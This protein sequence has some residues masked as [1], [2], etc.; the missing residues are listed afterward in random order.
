MKKPKK[1]K[2]KSP[3]AGGVKKVKKAPKTKKTNKIK[4][5]KETRKPKE[6]EVAKV[7]EVEATAVPFE[8]DASQRKRAGKE[9]K[10]SY[11][12]KDIYVLQGLEPVRKRPG[13]YIGSTGSEGLHHLI[14]ECVGNSVDEAIMG[15]CNKI[16]VTLLPEKRVKIEDNGRGIPVDRHS[17]TKKSALETIMTTLHAGGK[18]GSK[19]YVSTGGLHGVGLSVVCA[20]SKYMKAEI[21]RDGFKYTQEY[22]KGK[23]KTAVK[24]VG[25]CKTNGTTIIFEPD[26]EIFTEIKFNQKKILDYIRQQAYLT[27]GLKITLIDKTV[28][29][30]SSYG[31]YFEGGIVS[32]V[33]YL[34]RG[35]EVAHPNVFYCSGS[36]DEILVEAA[37]I[38][39]D[40]YECS[41]DSFANNIYTHEGGM[42]LTG[43]RGALTR[44][45]NDYA[46]RN[47]FLKESKNNFTG[48][49]TREGLTAVVSIKIRDPQF[50]G[51]TKAKLG[52]SEAKAVVEQVVGTDLNDFLE[53]NPNDARAIIQKFLLAQKARNAAKAVRDIILRKR[54]LDGLALPGKL[55]DCTSKKAEESELYI[56]EGESAGGSSRQARDR[57]FQAILPLRGKILNVERA[58][59]D[60]ILGSKEI[61]SLVIALGTAIAEDFNIEKIRYHHIIIMCDAD[62]DGNH[63]KALLLTLFY[64]YFKPLI[65]KGYIYLAQPPLYKIQAGKEIQYAY[66]ENQKANILKSMKDKSGISIQRY[67]GLGEMNA[68]ELW[69]T[70]MNPANRVFLQINVEDAREADKTF[71]TL[72]GREVPSRKKFIQSYAKSVKNLDI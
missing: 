58:R 65:E 69:D 31:F 66:A 22:S 67:K 52:N 43:F 30:E 34:I 49:D 9:E 60:K 26:P 28:K 68:G 8:T 55:A 37:F 10:S 57:H 11:T 40:E 44:S 20:L 46:K 64:R 50:E 32:Y 56:V 5:V 29:P 21:C 72:M 18:F 25:K 19:A 39:T 54:I 45:F 12:A 35:R 38:Y 3:P 23:A 51:Q 27:K 63:I 61:K 24:K 2:K 1:I 71:D 4:K 16:E 33:K 47:E 62:S 13:M 6:V 70:T 48:L 14:K 7:K 17:Q 15:C 42:H 36:K 53:R 41:E 59:L